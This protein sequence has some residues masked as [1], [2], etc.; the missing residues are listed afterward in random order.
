MKAGVEAVELSTRTGMIIPEAATIHPA[1]QEEAGPSVAAIT[2]IGPSPT[3][4]QN[5]K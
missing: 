4:Y 3:S 1:I 5:E 2:I